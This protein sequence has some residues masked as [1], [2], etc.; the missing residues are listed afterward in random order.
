[1][2]MNASVIGL[3]L[4]LTILAGCATYYQKTLRFQ[5]YIMEGQIEKASHWLEKNENKKKGKNE[6]LFYMYSGWVSWM[7][8]DY[9]SSNSQLEAADLLIEDY[10]KQFGYE[11]LSLISNPGVK[12]YQAEDF[13]KVMVNYY[14]ALNYIKLGNYEDGIVE[15][16]RI[17]IRLQRLNSK[18]KDHKNKYSD[19]AFAHVIIGML[20]EAGKDYNNA[21]IAYRNA[22][23]AYE[24]IYVENFGIEAPLQLKKDI[25]RSAYLTGFHQEVSYYE[26]MFGMTYE[27]VKDGGGEL[28][29]IWHNGFGPVKSEWSINFTMIPGDAGFVTYTNDEYGFTFPF[30]IGDRSP[31]EQ[32]QLRDLSILRV[33]FPKYLERLPVYDMASL[34]V[35][36][37][38]VPLELVE[39]INNIAFKTLDDRMLREFGNALLRVATKR[40]MEIAVREATAEHSDDDKIDAGDIAPAA[41]TIINAITEKADTRNWQTL[42]HSI[43][44]TKVRLPAGEHKVTLSTFGNQQDNLHELDIVIKEGKS[45]FFVFQSLESYLPGE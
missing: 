1:M 20:Y 37:Q 36:D 38:S 27:H 35:N 11:A 6:L 5:E 40:A 23:E 30:Y 15:A 33:A 41:V 7:L 9:T 29:F 44:Y 13:E 25:L 12:P 32:A 10:R 2:R 26:K 39:N 21:F 24:Y 31:E 18:Y 17:N 16:R 45:T 14:K 34:S 3:I 42:P 43:Y 8:G 28:I 22:L 19:D 4:L